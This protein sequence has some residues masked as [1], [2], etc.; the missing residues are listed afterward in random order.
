MLKEQNPPLEVH[1]VHFRIR[2]NDFGQAYNTLLCDF[3]K[4]LEEESLTNNV[5]AE[6][7]ASLINKYLISYPL[8]INGKVYKVLISQKYIGP[9]DNITSF[10]D[11]GLGQIKLKHLFLNAARRKM[12]THEVF[13]LRMDDLQHFQLFSSGLNQ[14]LSLRLQGSSIIGVHNGKNYRVIPYEQCIELAQSI[15]I[16]YI[17]IDM[18]NGLNMRNFVMNCVMQ[19]VEERKQFDREMKVSEL[20]ETPLGFIFGFI[21]FCF[22][23]GLYCMYD[24]NSFSSLAHKVLLSFYS[25]LLSAI[26]VRSGNTLEEEC[27]QF[28]RVQLRT[29]FLCIAGFS[30]YVFLIYQFVMDC[31]N[32]QGWLRDIICIVVSTVVGFLVT[33]GMFVYK[34]Y[35]KL[36]Y[37]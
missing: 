8:Q 19:T 21:I 36:K 26:L 31:V 7:Q 5:D 34:N 22:I 4:A 20:K 37:F 28:M 16:P 30:P 29:V 2:L 6:L 9:F 3:L 27:Q 18:S 15:G 1:E 23:F 10:K 32:N 12:L 11:R 33:L 35:Y 25:I 17:E 13:Y 14:L 24:A